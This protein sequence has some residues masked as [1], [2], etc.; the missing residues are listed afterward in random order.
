MGP[1]DQNFMFW[2]FLRLLAYKSEFHISTKVA[3]LLEDWNWCP[4]LNTAVLPT[5]PW[6]RRNLTKVWRTRNHNL[7]SPKEILVKV[8]PRRM[9]KIWGWWIS[10][11]GHQLNSIVCFSRHIKKLKMRH[12]QNICRFII[13]W[14]MKHYLIMSSTKG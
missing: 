5:Q 14:D 1:A 7:A 4:Q 13:K 11:V 8:W 2:I 6:R 10:L 9:N 12:L 3:C